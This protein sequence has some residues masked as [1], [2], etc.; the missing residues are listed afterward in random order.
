MSN[1]S[2]E[3]SRLI[4]QVGLDN[5][6]SGPLKVTLRETDNGQIA[7]LDVCSETL[8]VAIIPD[9]LL[10]HQRANARLIA[11]YPEM[12]KMLCRIEA[13]PTESGNWIS[14]LKTLLKNI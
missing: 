1:S 11:K 6:T 3:A 14:D 12:Y 10:P 8:R 7:G 2:E 5:S 9:G 4:N 13:S